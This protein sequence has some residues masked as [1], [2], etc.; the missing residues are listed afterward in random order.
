MTRCLVTIDLDHNIGAEMAGL[1]TLYGLSL[2]KKG[3]DFV[4]SNYFNAWPRQATIGHEQFGDSVRVS[5]IDVMEILR[6][7]NGEG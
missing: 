7:P 3:P 1:S 6:L 5:K 2:G 4:S